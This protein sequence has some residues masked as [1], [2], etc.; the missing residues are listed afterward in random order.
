A[1]VRVFSRMVQH[2]I[3]NVNQVP[4]QHFLAFLDLIGA[5]RKPPQPARV[6]LSFLIAKG[7]LADALVP[8]RT[9]VS[10]S[11]ADGEKGEVVFETDR[12]LVV[13]RAVLAAIGVHR[14]DLDRYADRGLQPLDG[15]QVLDADA[16]IEHSL[17][18]DGGDLLA[19]PPGT[20]LTLDIGL[21][22]I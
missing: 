21:P 10:A 8:A 1:L 4:N 20:S 15:P 11:L 16:P 19:L 14:P 18:V 2:V 7:A 22:P 17:F 9:L 6:P 12:E 3:D 5:Q 13:S